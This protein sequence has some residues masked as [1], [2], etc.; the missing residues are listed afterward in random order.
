MKGVLSHLFSRRGAARPSPEGAPRLATGSFPSAIYAVGDVHGRLDLL[1][2]LEA[3]IAAD[4]M[5]IGGECWIVMLG[6]YVDRGPSSAQTIDHLLTPP[7]DGLRRICLGGNH[8]QAMLEALENAEA[9]RWWLGFGGGATL[10]SYGVP[11]D[12]VGARWETARKRIARAIPAAHRAFLAGLPV[13]LRVP[14][15]I[16]V[17][18]GLMPGVA[19]EDQSDHDLRWIREPFLTADHDFGATVV[20]GHTMA[21]SVFV[22]PRRIG[23]D[24]G[25]YMSGRLAAVRLTQDAPPKIIE[26]QH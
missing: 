4:A 16:F 8:E 2:T 17:H 18:A 3:K 13:M 20:H 9:F 14:G 22:G 12:A 11:Q 25:A 23:L 10:A 26:I 7:P 19:P 1:R 5:E 6:D 21:A 15:Y 24:L